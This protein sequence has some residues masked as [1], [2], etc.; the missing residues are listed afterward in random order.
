MEGVILRFYKHK[1]LFAHGLNFHYFASYIG[2]ST[3]C[4]DSVYGRAN[5]GKC[6]DLC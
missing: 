1:Q 4:R 6:A 5:I 2:P 3:T